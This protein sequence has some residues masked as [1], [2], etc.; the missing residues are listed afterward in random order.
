MLHLK[1]NEAYF[2]SVDFCLQR[3]GADNG[4]TGT[5]DGAVCDSHWGRSLLEPHSRRSAARLSQVAATAKHELPWY[6]VSELRGQWLVK[7][8]MP[9]ISPFGLRAES[10]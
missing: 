5:C 3:T 9:Y 10:V 8:A 2:Y 1:N 7:A 6:D 4:V